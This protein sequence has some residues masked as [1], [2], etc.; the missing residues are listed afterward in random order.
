M[1]KRTKKRLQLVRVVDGAVFVSFTLC[2]WFFTALNNLSW[3]YLKSGRVDKAIEAFREA[4]WIETADRETSLPDFTGM[5]ET[6]LSVSQ[7]LTHSMYKSIF[8]IVSKC[9]QPV[10]I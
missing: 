4:M 2:C 5:Y 1:L 3:N 7:I 6:K 9:Q 10:C 8:S